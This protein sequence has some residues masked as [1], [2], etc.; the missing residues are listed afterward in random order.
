METEISMFIDNELGLSEKIDFIQKTGNDTDFRELTLTLL[1]QEK[2]IRMDP[3][4]PVICTL[5]KTGSRVIPLLRP[6][7]AL[8][9]VLI[10][11][12]SIVF[13]SNNDSQPRIVPYRF[14]IYQPDAMELQITGSF[15]KWQKLPMSRAGVGGYWEINLD[16]PPGEHRFVYILNSHEKLTDPTLPGIENDDFGGDNSI[17]QI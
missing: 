9:A 17:L 14:V 15:T 4:E 6:A 16:I 8:A 2:M 1:E 11:C 5:P 10:L 7:M 12:V 13:F 3:T